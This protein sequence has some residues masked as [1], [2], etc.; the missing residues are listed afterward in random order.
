MAALIIG[1]FAE[2]TPPNRKP[3]GPPAPELG[4]ASWPNAIGPNCTL[5][6]VSMHGSTA[7]FRWEGVMA[8]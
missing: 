3:L 8:V 2:A 4:D 5:Y 1:P 7:S 6:P